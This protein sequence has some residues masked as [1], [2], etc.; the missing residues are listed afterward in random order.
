MVEVERWSAHPLRR[1]RGLALVFSMVRPRVAQVGLFPAIFGANGGAGK[2][3]LKLTMA[4]PAGAVSSLGASSWHYPCFDLACR[5]GQRRHRDVIPSLEALS[6]S[7]LESPKRHDGVQVGGRLERGLPGAMYTVG[8]ASLPSS[9]SWF[10]PAAH[11]PTLRHL[12]VGGCVGC[13][14][15]QSRLPS[16]LLRS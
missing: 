12:R 5:I 16:F 7:L 13:A 15:L 6:R 10:G 2:P 1:Q 3:C 4:T 14:I 11:S 8:G 9:F